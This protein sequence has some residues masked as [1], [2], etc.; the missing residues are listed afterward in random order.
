MKTDRELLELAAKAAGIY[1][2]HWNDALDTWMVSSVEGGDPDGG[3]N[4]LTDDGAALRLVVDVPQ[5][6]VTRAILAA[7]Q[8]SDTT[9]GRREYVRRAIVRTAAAIGEALP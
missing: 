9:Y 7:W 6:G 1:L 5:I 3:W 4:P 8:E 2:H